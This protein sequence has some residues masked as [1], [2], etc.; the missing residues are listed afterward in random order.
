MKLLVP[1]MMPAIH[2]M[3]LA[4]RPSRSALMIGMPA[5]D[6]RFEGDHHA[7]LLRGGEDLVAVRREQRLVGGHHVLAVRDRLQHQPPGRLDAA[8]QLEHDVDIVPAHQCGRI[9]TDLDAGNVRQQRACLFRGAR[10]DVRDP[11]RTPG[12]ARDLLGIAV[13]DRPGAAPDRA[14]AEQPHAHRLHRRVRHYASPSSRNICLMPR[15][16]CRVRGSFSI[17]AKRT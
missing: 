2:S 3:R 9:R 8:D 14:Q 17:S 10:G 4:V 6:R 13:E 15:M 1:L 5:A 7:G 12:A 16:A 11:D